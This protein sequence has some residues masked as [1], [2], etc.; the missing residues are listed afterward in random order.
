MPTAELP[1]TSGGKPDNCNQ[2]EL[3]CPSTRVTGWVV[4]KVMPTLNPLQKAVA[5]SAV[6]IKGVGLIARANLSCPSRRDSAEDW[7]PSAQCGDE[8]RDLLERVGQWKR[9]LPF[10]LARGLQ[11][12]APEILEGNIIAIEP[13]K[14]TEL[15]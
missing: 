4:E 10:E 7:V 8:A 1:P 15:H 3:R 12:D 6:G 2:C 5:F 11:N 9:P 14:S 13:P